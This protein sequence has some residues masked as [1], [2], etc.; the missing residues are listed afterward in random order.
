MNC[1]ESAPPPPDGLVDPQGW[2][3]YWDSK[4]ASGGLLYDF[5]AEIYRKVLI[6]P[7]LN[8]FIRKSFSP[9]AQVL[10]AGCGSG[11]VDKDIRTYVKITALDISKNALHIY[12]RE[13]GNHCRI[14]HGSIFAL[15]FESESLDGI[16]NL[17]V[18]EHF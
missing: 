15:P 7:C 5:V 1:P 10:H 13:N 18:M 14:L 8:H 16:Y 3:Q 11:Q 2:D 4:K 9:G 17:G 6:R 12:Q